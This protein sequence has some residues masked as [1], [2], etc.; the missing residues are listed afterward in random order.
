VQIAISHVLG[1]E[2]IAA[3]RIP[4]AITFLSAAIRFE[5]R[6]V[7]V[8]RVLVLPLSELRSTPNHGDSVALEAKE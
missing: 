2:H 1:S 6:A 4:I 7:R 8:W 5:I 3:V